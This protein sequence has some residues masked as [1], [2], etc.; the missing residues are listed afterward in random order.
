MRVTIAIEKF[1]PRMGGAER[2][3]WDFAQFLQGQGHDVEVICMK[4]IQTVPPGIRVHR[5]KALRFP[6]AL[7]H[8]SFALLHFLYARSLKDSIHMVLGNAFFMDI[9]QPRGGIH[10]SWLEAENLRFPPRLRRLSLLLRRFMPKNAVQEAIEWWTFRVTRPVVI[11]ISEMIREDIRRFYSF[12]EEKIHL[13][14]NAVDVGMF[15]QENREFRAEIRARYGLRDDEF[16]FAFIANNP[17]LKGFGTLVQACSGLAERP[18]RV[19]VIGADVSWAKARAKEKALGRKFVF[20][21]HAPDIE[22]ILP[23]CDCLVHPSY[24]DSF[25]R[26]VIEALFSGIPVITTRSTGASM[27]VGEGDGRVIPP[28]D[29]EALTCAM[30][31]MLKAGPGG[32]KPGYV[33]AEGQDEA[34]RKILRVL[35]GI[36]PGSGV[37]G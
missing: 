4:A 24:Y 8:L 25:S 2:Y 31:E 19:L 1:D 9:Y 37:C 23:A 18:F 20:G 21:D 26:V 27:Y 6:Q 16:V 5:V 36:R 7:R 22:K 28:G 34:F 10:R 17:R 3:S 32:M 33:K 29:P 11:A 30:D 14:P 12:P 13:I 15:R 35:E